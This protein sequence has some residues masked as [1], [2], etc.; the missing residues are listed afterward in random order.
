MNTKILV[1]CHKKDVMATC[2]PYLPI[3]VGKVLSN[4]NLNITGDDS[5]DNI[6]NQNGSYCELTAMYWAWKNLK[7]VDIIGLNHY[8]RYFDFHNQCYKIFH[9]SQFETKDFNNIK[10]H[11][12]NAFLE[13]IQK[14]GIWIVAK[15]K[16]YIC[17]IYT[18]YCRSH[19]SDDIR[20]LENIIK[21]TQSQNVINAFEKIMFKTNKLI[22]YNMFIM[23][24]KDFDKYCQWLFPI[25]AEAEKRINIENYSASEKRIFGYMAERLFNVYIEAF[26]KKTISRPVIWF[27][28][29]F[30]YK[31]SSFLRYVKDVL[32]N[33]SFFI[34]KNI[35]NRI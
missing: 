2:E 24:W 7:D 27:N 14:E 19:I 9:C 13:K 4:I 17:S 21:E 18:D 34:Q 29:N 11:I 3:H 6:S 15:K 22:H 1:A 33:I 10:L 32:Y 35:A 25:L 30:K 20:T 8:R 5:G 12:P 23:R 31:E 26:K 28:D 16:T